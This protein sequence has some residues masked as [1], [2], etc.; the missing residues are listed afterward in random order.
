VIMPLLL[1]PKY[2]E[3]A[4]CLGIDILFG[5]QGC[6]PQWL[7]LPE[8]LIPHADKVGVPLG[9]RV[10]VQC[11]ANNVYFEKWDRH[12]RP[13][14]GDWFFT[15]PSAPVGEW[16]YKV[17][18]L[19]ELN[20][21]FYTNPLGPCYYVARPTR[22]ISLQLLDNHMVDY[23]RKYVSPDV[24]V[25]IPEEG[26]LPKAISRRKVR[27]QRFPRNRHVVPPSPPQKFPKNGI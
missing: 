15:G 14:P 3:L 11:D 4:G 6:L 10:S 17:M 13:M 21:V 16:A 9:F 23:T 5:E 19:R 27:F 22:L 18:N 1:P 8:A 7:Y 12:N 25:L 26:V 20:T 24:T 2:A